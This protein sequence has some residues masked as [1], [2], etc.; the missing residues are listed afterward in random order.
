MRIENTVTIAAPIEKVW[1]ITLDVEKWPDHTPTMTSIQ[2]LDSGPLKVGSKVQIK[3]PGQRAKTWT[4]T[5][6]DPPTGF[7]WSTRMAGTTLTATHL[8]TP[9]QTGTTN[10]LRVDLEGP[11]KVALGAML[12]RPILSAIS[13]ENE[14]LKAAA[15][16]A[17]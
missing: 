14:G 3:Q 2:R 16:G 12:R 11:R 15:E 10:S 1:D 7:A 8:L 13:K 5:L 9:S 17:S 6:V 4:V